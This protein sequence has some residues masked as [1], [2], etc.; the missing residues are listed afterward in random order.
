[1]QFLSQRDKRWAAEKLGQSQSTVGRYGCTI[2]SISMGTD[3]FKQWVTPFDLAH[4]LSFTGGG[5]I[6]WGS[7]P[8]VTCLKLEK[9]FFGQQDALIQEALKNPRKVVL[10]Q[11]ENYHWVLGLGR[12]LFGGY[13][14]ADPWFGDKS[15]T[16]RYK[17]ISGGAVL[18]LK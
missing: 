11:V 18:V 13:K 12:N 1:M 16:K 10:I 6:L 8:S 7:L 15:T 9:R 5:S 3:Y 2:T 14:I 17:N 4:K